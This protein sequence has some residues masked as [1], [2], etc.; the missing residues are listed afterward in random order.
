[1][2]SFFYQQSYCCFELVAM[3]HQPHRPSRDPHASLASQVFD[4]VVD[5]PATWSPAQISTFAEQIASSPQSVFTADFLAAYPDIAGFEVT[6]TSELPPVPAGG[7]SEEAKIGVGVGVGV[8]GAAIGTGTAGLIIMRRRR[9][10]AVEPRNE[11]GADVPPAE[12]E[13]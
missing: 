12:D 3:Y 4:L 8:G 9:R 5:T 6:I 10:A 7:L 11:L 2:L 1:L 13:A